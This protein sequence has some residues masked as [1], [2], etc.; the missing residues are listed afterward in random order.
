MFA[1]S[2]LQGRQITGGAALAVLAFASWRTF[3]L[4]S[5]RVFWGIGTALILAYV[6]PPLFFGRVAP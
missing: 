4:Q 6:V 1:F 5:S 3:M 2:F